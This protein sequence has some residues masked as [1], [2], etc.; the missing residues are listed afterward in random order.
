VL[1]DLLTIQEKFGKLKGIKMAYICGDARASTWV[2]RSWSAAPRWGWI[3][4]P[5]Q[6]KSISRS[7][8]LTDTAKELAQKKRRQHQLQ[9][10]DVFEGVKDAGVIIT[11]VWVSMGDTNGNLGR[12]YFDLAPYQVNAR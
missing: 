5:A 6:T 10:E 2:I 11:D 12:A 4:L 9:T 3:S 8:R 7:R 1:A